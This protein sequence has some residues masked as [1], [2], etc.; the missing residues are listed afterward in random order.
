MEYTLKTISA[1]GIAEALK[2]AERYRLLNHPDEAESIC[3]DIL[4]IEPESQVALRVLGLSLTDEFTGDLADRHAEAA[5]AFE[6]L[7]DPYDRVYHLGVLCER[8]A[9][10]QLEAGR[11]M[12]TLVAMF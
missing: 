10:A 5:A 9:K 12:H 8:R 6:K 4:A 11:A 3:H 2:K 1:S 7:S